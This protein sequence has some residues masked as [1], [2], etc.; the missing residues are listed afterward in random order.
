MKAIRDITPLSETFEQA[1][2]GVDTKDPG[3][4]G[5]LTKLIHAHIRPLLSFGL[6][7]LAL[8]L[9]YAIAYTL[10]YSIFDNQVFSLDGWLSTFGLET[11]VLSIAQIGAMF[12]FGGYDF[13]FRTFLARRLSRRII[14]LLV[15]TVIGIFCLVFAFFAQDIHRLLILIQVCLM[16]PSLALTS[17]LARWLFTVLGCRSVAVIV[18]ETDEGRRLAEEIATFAQPQFNEMVVISAEEYEQAPSEFRQLLLSSDYCVFEIDE[19]KSDVYWLKRAAEAQTFRDVGTNLD[20]FYSRFTGHTH[21]TRIET[22]GVNAA[23]CNEHLCSSSFRMTQRIRDITISLA[24]LLVTLPLW[25]IVA[26]LIKLDSKG[27]V[28]FKQERLGQFKKPFQCLKFRTM[29]VD[30]EQKSGPQ[31]ATPDDPRVI[32]IGRFLRASRLDELPQLLNVLRGDMGI[33]GP[34]PIRDYFARQYKEVV[35]SYDL[36][37][38]VKPGL[39]GWAQLRHKYAASEQDQIDKFRYDMFYLG[40]ASHDLDLAIMIG[41][42]KMLLRRSGV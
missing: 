10:Y 22:H 36:R 7:V 35:P 11:T 8:C 34:R 31:W 18:T 9:N 5:P 13:S 12:L 33:V 4:S 24:A 39:T 19:G 6:D 42:L 40:E 15:G 29:I 14:G 1:V 2:S 20:E 38:L 30:A 41:T 32:R 26:V 25:L 28:M 3:R 16:I 23:L 27:P 37:F 21:L 17:V